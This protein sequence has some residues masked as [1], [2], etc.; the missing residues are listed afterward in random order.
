[1]C[2]FL[3]GTIRTPSGIEC[4]CVNGRI[5]KQTS[6]WLPP[7][8]AHCLVSGQFTMLIYKYNELCSICKAFGSNSKCNKEKWNKIRQII[9]GNALPTC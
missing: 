3:S 8:C 9:V 1:M 7:H 6:F 5:S 2:Q 4:K